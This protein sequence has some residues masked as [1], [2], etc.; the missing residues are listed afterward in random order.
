MILAEQNNNKVYSDGQETEHRMLEIARK[1]PEEES[2]AYIA[3]NYDYTTNNTFSS[4]RQN[5]LNWYPFRSDADVLEIGAGMGSLTGLLCKKCSSVTAVEMSESRAEV[6]RARYPKRGNLN[7]VTGDINNIN[8]GKQFD[9]VV[10]VGVL[11]YAAV[12]SDS[13]N[14][15]LEFLLSAKSFL[16]PDGRLLFAIENQYGLKYWCGA[17]EDH[18]QKAFAGIEGYKQSKLPRTFSKALLEKMLCDAGLPHKRVYGVV[19]DYKFPTLLF[20]EDWK[21]TGAD[22]KNISYT[23]GK[24]SLLVAD[25]RDIYE[26]LADNDVMMFFANS[27]FVEASATELDPVYP[28]LI[29]AK[30]ENKPEYRIITSIFSDNTISKSAA[31]PD[32]GKHL[33]QIDQYEDILESR[34]VRVL[35]SS[36][37]GGI[38]KRDIVDLQRAD[39]I[40]RER[41]EQGDI[42]GVWELVESLRYNL[43]ASS[44]ISFEPD[45]AL[46]KAG[47]AN[48]HE[49]FGVLLQ[50]GYVDMTFYNAFW[51]DG[52][53]VFFDQ[54]WCISDLPLEFILYYAVKSVFQRCGAR[55][56]IPFSNALGYLN[57]PSN[58]TEYYDRMEDYIWKQVF[59]RQ[60]DFYGEGGYCTQY[61]NTAKLSNSL[62]LLGTLKKDIEQYCH[63]IACKDAHIELL[64]QSERDLQAELSSLKKE[65]EEAYHRLEEEKAAE[66]HLMAKEKDA[67]FQ[68][69]AE[70]K[71]AAFQLMVEEKG[72]NLQ[73]LTEEKNAEIQR[74][75]AEKDTA[76]RVFSDEKGK[77]IEQLQQMVRNKEGH[78]QQLLEP[79]RELERIKNSRSWR[80]MGYAWRIRDILV[81][82]G[83]RRRLFGKVCIKFV[84]H[85]IRFI[86]KC[87]PK[88]IG[89][90]FK[91]MRR[92][93][94]EGTSRRLDDCLIGNA[95]PVMELA[96]EN[97]E[98]APVEVPK[99]VS[100]YEP[101]DVPQ[102]DRPA[103]SILIPAYNQ[104]DYTYLCIKSII[105][106]SGDV[107]YEIILADDCSNDLTQEVD[108]IIKG[109]VTVVNPHN[110]RFLWNCNNAAHV[111]RGE[112][113]LFLNNDTQVQDNWLA[114]LVKLI[115]SDKSIGMVGSKLVYP[116]GRL[117]E[118]G[119]IL[120][121]DGSAWNYGNRS[122]PDA[123]E[124]NYVK[125]ADYISGASIMIR[126]RLWEEIGGFDERFV[127][128]YCED[129]D[130]AFE[131]RRR[132]YKVMYQPQSVVV[133][134]EGVSNGTNTT[135]GQKAYQ[136]ANQSKFF[137]KWESVLNG[138]HFENGENVFLAR[139]RA[140]GAKVLLMV[141]HYVPQFDKDAGSRT[142]FQ[143]IQLFVSHGYR[144]KF[145]GDN[146]Y[147]H[148]PYTAALQ[149]MG[150]EV[151][152]G[153]Y[154]AAHWKD[155][156]KENGKYISYAFLNRPHISEKYIDLVRKYTPAKIIYYGHDLHFLRE[157]REYELTG[158][159]ELLKSSEDWKKKELS[160]MRKADIAY[161]PSCVEKEEIEKIAPDI[162][163]KAIPAYI[164]NDVSDLYYNAN[165]R[166]DLMFIGGF[167]HR[168]NVDAVK[169]LA[170]AIMPE[171]HKLLPEVKV[172]I[173]GSNPPE[174]LK[175]LE[176]DFLCLEGFVT[177]QELD[178][179][180]HSCRIAIVP[181][182]Y[183]AGIKGKVVEAMRFGIPVVTTSVGA[184]GI[185]GAE[186]ILIIADNASEFARSV[187][188]LYYNE[189]ELPLRSTASI[190]YVRENFSPRRADEAVGEDFDF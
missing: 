30:G 137:E 153:P 168:P 32:A 150:V 138:G 160:L 119:G 71:D 94:V 82:K 47:I 60:G 105:E 136:M 65:N 36:F 125:E 88:R 126:R 92:E 135:Q 68:L 48:S 149:Q 177:D 54:E 122:D 55:S 171:L 78:I 132:G 102:W 139:E 169:W 145:I 26:D 69:M 52:E 85:P 184:E 178:T 22:M 43:L 80:F 70:E 7:V 40:F 142:V 106:H 189:T 59:L 44:E 155:W 34:G 1:Y 165:G 8:L 103:V 101:L 46:V 76:F 158:M 75:T 161:Y 123:P 183:G 91:T 129:S 128:A 159:Q 72:A 10:F 90:F 14:P 154:Y 108:A 176:T 2:E 174:E 162:H 87:T 190:Q 116:D 152:Y 117:Q 182:R 35:R 41:L 81:P 166:K 134:F 51:D 133:H 45:N 130:L 146:F 56:K 95:V 131:V 148:Q 23:Y 24:N 172:H 49:N 33:K 167:N 111:T 15:Y 188:A 93:G 57:I 180:Y 37:H 181:L 127:P 107:S 38:L 118:A 31:H 110:L 141:D 27:F 6:I 77:E 42:N 18:L 185:D 151:L 187:A 73:R 3:Q 20:S 96:V 28:I 143:Y 79:E 164:F 11:E 100:D 64:L 120:W 140:N 50:N 99:T 63:D 124:Y 113:I 19:P 84:K 112:Y 9:Y 156:L 53:L 4:V 147:A 17:A 21:P 186:N 173:Y 58:R 39:H 109:L 74:L 97:V 89:K 25:E 175:D 13:S 16:K 144:V 115:E 179:A 67:A 157:Q 5:L 114:P 61:H 121:K 29:T 86:G 98:A 83:S 62:N 12:F 163:V 66:L 170:E 104:F